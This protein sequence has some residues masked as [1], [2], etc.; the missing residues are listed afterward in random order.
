MVFDIS[1][2]GTASSDPL[3][4]CNYRSALSCLLEWVVEVPIPDRRA[5]RYCF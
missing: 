2:N 5:F 1:Q 3:V 4:E